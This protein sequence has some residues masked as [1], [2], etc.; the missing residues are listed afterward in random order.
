MAGNSRDLN[1]TDRNTP[2][3]GVS[4]ISL[5]AALMLVAL[6]LALV[7]I[8]LRPPS[9]LGGDATAG[10]FSAGRALAVLRDLAGDEAPHPVGSAASARVR[11]RIAAR[12]Q[13]LGLPVEVQQAFTCGKSYPVCGSVANVLSRLPGRSAGPAVLLAAHYDSVPAGPGIADDLASV[14]A[15]IEVARALTAG[16][17]PRNPVIFL[18]DEGE[19]AG[20]LGARAF[21]ARHPWAREVGAAINMEARGTGG[22]SFMFETSDDNAWLIDAYARAVRRPA[23]LSLTYEVYK[24]LPNDTDFTVFKRAGVPGLNFAFIDEVSH[25]H[26]PM[27][28]LA[29]LDAGSLQHQGESVLAVARALA[30]AD[31]SHPPNGRAS[32]QDI[33]GFAL[34]KWP[35]GAGLPL[36]LAGGLFLLAVVA[37]WVSSLRTTIPA[38]LWGVGGFAAVVVAVPGCGFL[39]T[40][41]VEALAGKTA[42]WAAHPLPAQCA[43]WA[44]TAATGGTVASLASRRAGFL[45]LLAGTWLGWS[46]LTIA[47]ATAMPGTVTVFLIPLL[48]AVLLFGA[49]EGARTE[50]AE[51]AMTAACALVV[52]V[53]AV[54][55]LPLVLLLQSAVGL[56]WGLAVTGPLGMVVA[57]LTPLAAVGP[58]WRRARTLCLCAAAFATLIAAAAAA[59]VRPYSTERPQHLNIVYL[60]D[61]DAGVRRWVAGSPGKPLPADLR[62]AAGFGAAPVRPFPWSDLEQFVAPAPSLAQPAA[63][64][65]ETGETRL[66]D[67]RAINATLR[68]E[69]GAPVVVLFL[70]SDAPVLSLTADGQPVFLTPTGAARGNAYRRVRFFGVHEHGVRLELRLQGNKPLEILIAD[71]SY[72]LPNGGE[73]LV[74]AR[75]AT[76]VP[77]DSGDSTIVVSRSRL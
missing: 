75:P 69:R 18:L 71:Q 24:R 21:V 46:V 44:A 11:E 20:L 52:G 7:A 2:P 63:T 51:I 23:A 58:R 68:S 61:R 36:A 34:L 9:P 12:L 59:L 26:T 66:Q 47:A 14:A 15:I 45:G 38:I 55:W 54:I 62:R 53:T 19:E 77:S 48:A 39:V 1:S 5:G 32:Y 25:Y 73:A 37:R 6:V 41:L 43:L 49:V 74:S 76:A 30:E 27:D 42:P 56:G 60:D 64:L 65:S 17:A 29:H 35:A 28:D 10:E 16:P 4:P 70:P 31:L 72:G 67:G 57:T 3:Q 33:L 22:L 50:V 13:N 8:R 40:R